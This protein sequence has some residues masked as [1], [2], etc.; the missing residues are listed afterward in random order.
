[1]TKWKVYDSRC[2]LIRHVVFW[3]L[4]TCIYLQRLDS[5]TEHVVANGL[6]LLV[7]GR[8]FQ[9]L[10]IVTGAKRCSLLMKHKTTQSGTE[11]MK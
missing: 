3:H 9:G 11:T 6:P 5:V 10:E 7:H 2:P 4:D 1:M 8:P